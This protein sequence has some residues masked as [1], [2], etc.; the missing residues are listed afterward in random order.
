YEA[1]KHDFEAWFPKLSSTSFVFFHD[2][3]VRERNFG[4]FKFWEELKSK[5]HHFQF[6]FGCGLGL[7]CIGRIIPEEI[8]ELFE[9]GPFSAFLR[10]IFSER[11]NFFKTNSSKDLQREREGTSFNEL[12]KINAQLIESSKTLELSNAEL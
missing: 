5:Y 3:N 7:I 2:I 9:N 12:A 4:V 6:D 1:V 10:N 8:K 11:G